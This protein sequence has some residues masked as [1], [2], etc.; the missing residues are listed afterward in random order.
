[1][2]LTVNTRLMYRTLV[3]NTLFEPAVRFKYLHRY[4]PYPLN[5][6]GDTYMVHMFGLHVGAVAFK[7]H[8]SV[9]WDDGWVGYC[10]A[11][12]PHIHFR[13][14]NPDVSYFWS[15]SY[16]KISQYASS[17]LIHDATRMEG[18]VLFVY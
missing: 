18:P 12:L 14:C 17:C 10:A 2:T 7:Q 13:I 1:M 8:I 4:L 15:T 9:F 16:G 5:H 3:C 6:V 11:H